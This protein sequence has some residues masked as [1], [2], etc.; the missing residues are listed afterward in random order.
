MISDHPP[1]CHKIIRAD[2]N[3]HSDKNLSKANYKI[4]NTSEF[5]KKLTNKTEINVTIKPK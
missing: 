3:T 4:H 2:L 5:L 1:S